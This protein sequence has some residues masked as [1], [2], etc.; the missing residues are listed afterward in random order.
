MLT[1]S[2]QKA[3]LFYLAFL[4]AFMDLDAITWSELALLALIVVLA[5]GGV[6]VVHAFAAA[7][8]GKVLSGRW[9]TR[10]QRG[11]G[12]MLLLVGVMI[13]VMA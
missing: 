5:V 7:R 11:A 6:K 9:N 10:L 4:P 3:I 8:T 12:I 13:L 2:D 1:L